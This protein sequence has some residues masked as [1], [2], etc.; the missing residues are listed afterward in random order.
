L[1]ALFGISSIP[2]YLVAWATPHTTADLLFYCLACI[3]L[4]LSAAVQLMRAAVGRM[5]AA[6]A[7][8]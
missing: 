4:A 3:G 7:R 5:F 2:T 8:A 1:S 6:R